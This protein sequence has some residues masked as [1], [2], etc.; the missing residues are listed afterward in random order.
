MPSSFKASRTQNR[1]S[2]T[3]LSSTVHITGSKCSQSGRVLK[4][5]RTSTATKI[6]LEKEEEARREA[7][8]LQA[9]TKTQLWSLDRLRGDIPDAFD[10]NDDYEQDILHGHAA[11]DI[12]HAG[13]V[14]PAD[15]ADA[16]VMAGL[17]ANHG[18]LWGRYP[19]THTRKNHTQQQVDT[20][21]AQLDRMTDAYLDVSLAIADEGLAASLPTPEDSSVQET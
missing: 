17:R 1:V 9:M 13:E 2:A 7:E 11:A 21:N 8:R 18:Q 14:L 4:Q 12:S 6:R 3:L 15:D 10:D 5:H 16:A 19:D 20:F